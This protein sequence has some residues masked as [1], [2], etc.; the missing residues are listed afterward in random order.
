MPTL[1]AAIAGGYRRILS[2][3]CSQVTVMRHLFGQSASVPLLTH[4]VIQPARFRFLIQRARHTLPFRARLR[5]TRRTVPVA[6]VAGPA[7]RY[8]LMTTFAVED[9]AVWFR[10]P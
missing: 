10:H 4:F 5:S 2:A 6:T 7:D 9:P 3:G 8:L 1:L